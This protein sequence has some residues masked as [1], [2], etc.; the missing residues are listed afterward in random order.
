MKFQIE[1]SKFLVVMVVHIDFDDLVSKKILLF[2][3][4]A[5]E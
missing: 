5:S 1:L 2:W 3:V 4:R